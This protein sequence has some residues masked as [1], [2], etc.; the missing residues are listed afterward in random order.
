LFS[1]VRDVKWASAN[2]AQPSETVAKRVSA[3]EQRLFDLVDSEAV[4]LF[5]GIG[6]SVSRHR[7]SSAKAIKK[8]P[9]LLCNM[10]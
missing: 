5:S 6:K 10:V 7:D 1:A 8:Q 9:S 3:E 2:H 4:K